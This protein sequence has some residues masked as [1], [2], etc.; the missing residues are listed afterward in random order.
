MAGSKTKRRAFS[1]YWTFI[2]RIGCDKQGAIAAGGCPSCGAE[3]K[4]SMAGVCEF[5]R[6]KVV[7]GDFGWVLSAIEQDEEYGG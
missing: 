3:L 2:R 5:C 6:S 7:T 1:E 4:I